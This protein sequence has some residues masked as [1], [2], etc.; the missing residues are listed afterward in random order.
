MH[1][2]PKLCQSTFEVDPAEAMIKRIKKKM[3]GTRRFVLEVWQ[4]KVH[5]DKTKNTAFPSFSQRSK[6]R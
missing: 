2:A 5:Q 4:C 3:N 6:Q 1:Q